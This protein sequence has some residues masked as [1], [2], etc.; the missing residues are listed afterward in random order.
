M[1][2]RPGGVVSSGQELYNQYFLLYALPDAQYLQY[3]YM[4]VHTSKDQM[5]FC[6]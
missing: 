1:K 4:N 5:S 3:H 6:A 2:P